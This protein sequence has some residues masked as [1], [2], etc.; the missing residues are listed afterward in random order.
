MRK[1]G[2]CEI[3]DERDEASVPMSGIPCMVNDP[4]LLLLEDDLGPGRIPHEIPL[5]GIPE[6]ALTF[7]LSILQRGET[8]GM[9]IWKPSASRL[10]EMSRSNA[11]ASAP[12]AIPTQI[13]PLQASPFI[14]DPDDQT[15]GLINHLI[16]N[17]WY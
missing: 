10:T 16:H 7:G 14:R 11:S 12:F 4:R 17:I 8:S 13:T 15:T 2:A 1:A 6:W 3:H 9:D 5:V